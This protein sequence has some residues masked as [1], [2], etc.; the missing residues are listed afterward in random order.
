MH[1][2]KIHDHGTEPVGLVRNVAGLQELDRS[3]GLQFGVEYM[4]AEDLQTNFI[5][6]GPVN[7][8]W[9]MIAAY[10]VTGVDL[11]NQM[12]SSTWLV[13]RTLYG[14]PRMA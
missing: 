1:L 14:L 10:H 6:I 3:Y 8:V 4:A 2:L 9:N 13:S 12:W 7:K 5:D 11:S